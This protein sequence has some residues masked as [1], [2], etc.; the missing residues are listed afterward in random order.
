MRDITYRVYKI[1][2]HP[3]KDRCFDWVRNNMHDLAQHEVDDLINSLVKLRETIGGQLHYS[4][5]QVPDRGEFIYFKNY[6][7]EAL[8]KLDEASC[9]LTG[10]FCDHDVIECI[11]NNDI[12]ELFKRLHD[13]CEYHYTDEAIEEQALAN[14]W[15][16]TIKGRLI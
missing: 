6:N 8:A 16:F 9:P 11:R 1:D 12:V 10:V 13:W 4:I 7:E 5:S 2:E 3:D 14:D 15:E